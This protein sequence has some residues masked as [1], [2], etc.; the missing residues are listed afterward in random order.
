M[1]FLIGLEPVLILYNPAVNA[2]DRS[3]SPRKVILTSKYDFC[4]QSQ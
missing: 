4:S 2:I 1:R 3:I